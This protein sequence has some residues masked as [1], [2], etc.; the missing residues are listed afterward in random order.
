MTVKA[1]CDIC[2]REIQA[3]GDRRSG[4]ELCRS[5]FDE[6]VRAVHR[7]RVDRTA[8]RAPSVSLLRIFG[9]SAA[10]QRASREPV[11][12]VRE[13]REPRAYRCRAC[14]APGH[15]VQTCQAR[16]VKADP[17]VAHG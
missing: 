8:A 14:G 3:S 2:S 5:C 15:N 10:S 9:A 17:V 11:R 13:P 7:R 12:V 4:L 1:K 16:V 6:D